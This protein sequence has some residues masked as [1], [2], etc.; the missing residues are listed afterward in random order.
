M[1]K[2][3]LKGR[4]IVEGK[5]RGEA[6]VSAMPINFLKGVD[7][8]SGRIIE[9]GHELEG[10][11]ITGKILCFPHGQGSTVGSYVIYALAKKGV[12]PKAIVNEVADPV[13]VVGAII[14]SIPMVDQIDITKIHSSDIVEVDGKTGTVEVLRRIRDVSH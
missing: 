11:V 12:G 2:M 6:L 7:V 5:V 13:I 14:G 9:E 10:K 4:P 3:V 1:G 8:E